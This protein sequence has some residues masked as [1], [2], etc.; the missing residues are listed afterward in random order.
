MW[1]TI[2]E[3]NLEGFTVFAGIFKDTDEVKNTVKKC[4]SLNEALDLCG[5]DKPENIAIT[6]NGSH[7]W[8]KRNLNQTDIIPREGCRTWIKVYKTHYRLF[9]FGKAWI[10]HH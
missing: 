3:I 10:D 8:V 6:T 2:Y 5:N 4:H 9:I 7:F 1:I